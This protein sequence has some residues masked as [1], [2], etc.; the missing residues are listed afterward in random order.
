MLLLNY[1]HSRWVMLCVGV[2]ETAEGQYAQAEE[3]G[4]KLKQLLLKTKKDLADA[5]KLVQYFYLLLLTVVIYMYLC[6]HCC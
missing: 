4:N 6:R 5:K 2:I 1:V 3:H